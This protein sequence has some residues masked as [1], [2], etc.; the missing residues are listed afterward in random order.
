MNIAAVYIPVRVQ[1]S[2]MVRMMMGGG[3]GLVVGM[4]MEMRMKTCGG[5]GDGGRNEGCATD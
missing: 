1:D 5:Y 4:M 3:D 2:D